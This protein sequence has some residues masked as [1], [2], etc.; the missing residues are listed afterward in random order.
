MLVLTIRPEESIT[1]GN[2][3]CVAVLGVRGRKVILGLKAPTRIDIRRGK[4]P[5]R[6]DRA[7]RTY[8]ER[9]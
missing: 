2:E 7:A 6:P 3:I 9:H 1:F 8:N 5:P 4:L